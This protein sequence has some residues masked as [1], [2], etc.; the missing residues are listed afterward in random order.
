[1]DRPSAFGRCWNEG[2]VDTFGESVDTWLKEVDP[3]AKRIDLLR[4]NI[5]TQHLGLIPSK[6]VDTFMEVSTPLL[7]DRPLGEENID[8][9]EGSSFPECVLKEVS[10]LEGKVSTLD[11]KCRYFG[12]KGRY[13]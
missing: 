9:R 13:F 2:E 11:H 3:W 10:I 7:R 12:R 8:T 5:S 6:E 4:R 1:M